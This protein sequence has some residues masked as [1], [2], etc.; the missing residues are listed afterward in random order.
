MDKAEKI[1]LEIQG[2]LQGAKMLQFAE[3]FVG[4]YIVAAINERVTKGVYLG[5]TRQNMGY[6]TAPIP[7]WFLGGLIRE[8]GQSKSKAAYGLNAQEKF[9]KTIK[10]P[11][12]DI[13][14]ATSKSG[15]TTAYLKGG[16][17][18][19]RTLA[20]RRS[21]IV[22]LT[23]TGSMLASLTHDTSEQSGVVSITVRVSSMN[24]KKA[25]YTN[26]A[27]EWMNVSAT[28]LAFIE[29]RLAEMIDP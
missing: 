22:D 24:A 15:R 11:Y 6:S 8:M 16:Y 12:N 14:W 20:G 7:T 21:D 28:E 2:F 4:P 17:S 25:Y 9:N 10:I 19:F 26:K 27:R 23:F 1:I 18:H 29:K 13:T 3:T 5:G